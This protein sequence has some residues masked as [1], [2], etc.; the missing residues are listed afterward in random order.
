MKKLIK[1]LLQPIVLEFYK[2]YKHSKYG[3]H[4][5]YKT[6]EEARRHCT[7]YEA[8]HILEKVR[9]S[10]LKVKRGEAV[11]ERDSVLFDEIQY[12][13]PLLAGLMLAAAKNN[14]R[15]VVLDVGGSLGST[16]FQ[17]KKFLDELDYVKWCVVEQKHFVDAGK[18][19]FED[20]RL[21]FYYDVKSCVETDKPNVLLLS[22]VLQYMEKPY[23]LLDEILRYNFDFVIVD[24]TPFDKIN[25]DKITVQIVP[26]SIYRASYPSW[27][28]SFDNFV[29]YLKNRYYILEIFDAIDGKWKNIEFKGLIGVKK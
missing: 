20:E 13:W 25:T 11:Y 10:L 19:D 7:G 4:G 16:Y 8:P 9:E 21:K 3:W 23:E 24:R 17:N 29:S 2:K 28:F 5:D 6:W 27:I 14:G 1:N 26:P 18:K 15:L 12:S 22:G